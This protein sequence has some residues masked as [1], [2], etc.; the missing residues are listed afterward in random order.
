M[1][2]D[3]GFLAPTLFPAL[4]HCYIIR[5]PANSSRLERPGGIGRVNIVV[6]QWGFAA[7]AGR[8]VIDYGTRTVSVYK[9]NPSVT[10]DSV[11]FYLGRTGV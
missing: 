3:V 11:F 6:R 7:Y 5:M 10:V 8:I 9:E 2:C 4:L 1:S